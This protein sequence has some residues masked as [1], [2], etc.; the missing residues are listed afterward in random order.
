[1]SAPPAEGVMPCVQDPGAQHY[2]PLLSHPSEN[3]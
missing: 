1:M 3:A 2:S